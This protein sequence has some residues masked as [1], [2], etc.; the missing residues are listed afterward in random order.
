[1]KS[2]LEQ[3]WDIFDV[4]IPDHKQDLL[5]ERMRKLLDG[6]TTKSILDIARPHDSENYHAI[7]NMERGAATYRER[8]KRYGN[9]YKRFGEIMMALFPDGL[10][11]NTVEHWNRMGVI[12]MII[13]KM[14]RYVTDPKRGHLDSAHD[15]GVYSF[16]LE[17]LDAEAEGL[18]V[19]PPQPLITIVHDVS[20]KS[21]SC[22]HSWQYPCSKTTSIQQRCENF[23][24]V[25]GKARQGHDDSFHK[26]LPKITH[27]CGK[28]T[29]CACGERGEQ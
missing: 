7:S 23:C 15:M 19:T 17:E 16:M 12:H 21:E 2:V 18:N 5:R 3:I 11:I 29:C 22:E 27:N 20:P 9:N 10:T 14:S 6:L 25:C 24:S 28:P 4:D 26:F 13:A 8:N 1:M